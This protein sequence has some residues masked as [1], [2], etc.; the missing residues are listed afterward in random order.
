MGYAAAGGFYFVGVF[1]YVAG[2]PFAFIS[3]HGLS[4]SSTASSLPP[5]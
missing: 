4:P 1:A 2:T 3:Y 5:G